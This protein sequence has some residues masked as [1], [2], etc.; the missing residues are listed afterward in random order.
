MTYSKAYR[1]RLA[2][3]TAR[4]RII[5]DL[6]SGDYVSANKFGELETGANG[7]KTQL[8]TLNAE[9]GKLKKE[10]GSTEAL[11][12]G[13]IG[14]VMGFDNYMSQAVKT[15]ANGTMASMAVDGA[16]S[17]G[18]TVIHVDGGTGTETV[19]KGTIITISGV[20][21]TVIEDA[22]CTGGECDLN[23]YPAVPAAIKDN[24]AVTITAGHTA[25]LVFNPNAFAFV[26]ISFIMSHNLV[27]FLQNVSF[28]LH[29]WL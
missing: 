5:A 18:A 19:T 16:V 6:S 11:R 3:T 23:V 14:R 12:N 22:V 9:I 28:K 8:E 13:S 17:E 24:T 15:H 21:Y 27:L 29:L 10:S 4:I 1:T 20:N 7:Y 25:N 2:N 26:I